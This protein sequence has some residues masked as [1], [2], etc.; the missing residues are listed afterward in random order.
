[1]WRRTPARS[2]PR[3]QCRA[4]TSTAAGAPAA[5]RPRPARAMSLPTCWRMAARPRWPKP[6]RWSASPPATGSPST[7]PPA[8]PTDYVFIALPP[9]R[10]V[11]R[12]T[13]VRLRR[14]SL[15]CP[16][17]P[18]RGGR[19]RPLG[20]LSLHAPEPEGLALG[21]VAAHCGL[22]QG[23]RRQAPH[24]QLR[25]RRQLD[26]GRGPG[27]V[28]D[29]KG[30]RP[31]PGHGPPDADEPPGGD[32]MSGTRVRQ[33]AARID[34][35]RQL[36]FSFNGRD[37]TGHPGDTL[38]S[39]LLAQG[40]RCVARSFKYGR[41]RGIIGAGAEEPNALVQL[42]VGALTTPNV[43][44]TQAE[45]YE[46]LVAHSTSGWPSLAF[47][48]KSLLGRGARSMMPAGF[49]GKT[50]KWPRRLW[51][52]Y[53]A[54]L[55][56][57][58]GWGAAPG[59]PDPERYDHLHH[60]VDVLVVGAGACGLLAALQAGQAGLKTLLLDEQN[61]LGGWL[62]SDPR[63]R[64]DGR[65]GPAYIRSVQ[66]ALPGLPQVRVLTRTTPF[67]I[68]KHNDLPGVMTVS[69][70]QTFLQRYGVRVG[71]RVVICGTSD[72]IHDCAEDLAQAGARVVVADVRHGATARSSAYQVLG[73]HG[74][75]R[76][77]GPGH[78]K[79]A[80]LVPLHATR[81]EATSAGRHVACDVVLSSGGLSP[82]VHLF[83]HDGSRPLWDDA[84][85][86]FVAPGAGRPGVACV[87]AVTGAFELPAAL[88][89]TTQAMHRVLAACGRQRSLQ[90]P[91][92]P[93]T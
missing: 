6:S 36:R 86:A 25:G 88:A 53:E 15:H 48:L 57:C 62:L 24:R 71:Q 4:C 78:V 45:L 28:A 84:A 27:P 87:G 67:P 92:C 52:L 32:G 16:P 54:V 7:P 22:P 83:C 60:H 63:A 23:V 68:Y 34:G 35:S 3:P 38:A 80:H 85:A 44:A 91:V 90:T 5:S 50:F 9:L 75:A 69:A 13:R 66:S 82:T 40:V 8:S 19:G 76:A 51:P 11:A 30:P 31:G 74:I 20:R 17:G 46:G 29:G 41:P 79:S 21:A 65:D 18:A 26:A 64:M 81:E 14:R 70:G 2:F 59:L 12:R 49:Y 56:R 47:D 61:E 42:G 89:Q 58:A 55:R 72:L 73:A 93:P 43:K 33:P 39:A 1:M 37:Y 10:R 77:M